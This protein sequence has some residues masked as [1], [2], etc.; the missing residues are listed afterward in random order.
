MRLPA[1]AIVIALAWHTPASAAGLTDAGDAVVT[2]SIGEPSTLVP[3]VAADSASHGICSLLFNGLVKYDK[4]LQLAGDLAERWE[5]LDRGLTLRFHLRR[6]V[7]WHDGAPFTA[8]DVRFTYDALINPAVRT[9]YR[10]DFE[11]IRALRILD[12]WT[13]EITYAE[14]FAPGLASWTMWI[15]PRHLLQGQDL[16][17][18]PFAR[19]PVGT[20][21]YR[22]RRWRSAELIELDANPDYF[23]GAPA[24]R[25]WI[26]RIIPDEATTFLE[27]QTEGV[28]LASLTPLQYQRQ[29]NTPFF[30]AHYQRARYPS[31]GY[32]YLGYNL[33]HPLFQDPG[34]R[35]ALNLAIDKREIVQ[36]ALLGLGQVATGPFLPDSWAFDP[37][38]AAAPYDPARARALL[39]EAGWRDTDGDGWLDRDG[40]P[41]AFTILTNQN[42][43]RELTAQ[44]IQQRLKAIGIRVQ[45][46]VVEWSSLLAHFIHPR[47]FEAILM[48]WGLSPEPDPYDIWHSSKTKP[49]EFNFIGYAN[50]VV[51]RLLEDGRQTFDQTQ[52]AA[53]YHELQRI[54]YHE[55]PVCFLYVADALPII[56]RRIRNIEV[57]PAGFQHNLVEW[58]VPRHEHRYEF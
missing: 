22:F 48:G 18:T 7:R 15:M 20:G 49:G 32:T 53:I 13:L 50:P 25:G 39:A 41:F 29:T 21:P 16:H 8:D 26:E 40:R 14:P 17:T 19:Q 57:T 33:R 55:Q 11:R 46:R 35:Q 47:R 27:L 52:R 43:T 31:F 24:I 38:V 2:A 4:T 42:L 45:V 37:A 56:H 51:D 28:D 9:P 23:A 1:A 44:I 54:L 58:Y 12:P 30:A 10:G 3:I 36:G 5:A 6:D 34:V